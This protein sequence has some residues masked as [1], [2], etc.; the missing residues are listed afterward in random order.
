MKGLVFTEFLEMVES[1]YGM[2]TT[3]EL[4]ELPTHESKGIYTSVGTYDATELVAMV[5]RLAEMTDASI[6]DL[7]TGFGEYLFVR[8]HEKYPEMFV[9]KETASQFLVSVHGHIHVEVR[10]LYPEASL[11][12]FAYSEREGALVMTYSSNRPFAMLA[13][14]LIRGSL[15]HFGGMQSV[16]CEL[17][18]PQDGTH[19]AFTIK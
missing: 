13:L 4:L 2:E 18:A 12:E 14:G 10:K 3:D 17:L 15:K 9:E 7:L 8:F 16:T 19:A 1:A 6:P 11:P 5:V